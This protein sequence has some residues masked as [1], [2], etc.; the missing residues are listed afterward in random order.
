M[1]TEPRRL[2]GRYA[3]IVPAFTALAAI[4]LAR[5]VGRSLLG[6]QGG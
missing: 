2:G 4:D 1:A 3:F 6:A 5:R